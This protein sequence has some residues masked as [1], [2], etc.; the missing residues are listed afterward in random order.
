MIEAK[1]AAAAVAAAQPAAAAAQPAAATAIAHSALALVAHQ[2]R[3]QRC[4]GPSVV[5]VP[6]VD[7]L[8]DKASLQPFME[9]EDGLLYLGGRH[10]IAEMVSLGLG[11]GLG[12]G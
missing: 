2:Q 8:V 11:L 12:L 5:W 6:Y 9:R 4:G 7:T 1:L 3:Q 10:A